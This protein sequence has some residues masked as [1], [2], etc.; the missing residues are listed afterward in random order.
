[1]RNEKL[2]GQ[3][4]DAAKSLDE[5]NDCLVSSIAMITGLDYYTVHKAL[6][7]RGRRNRCST[8]HKVAR[9]ALRDLGFSLF[10]FKVEK[11]WPQEIGLTT[12][13]LLSRHFNKPHADRIVKQMGDRF[14]AI[15]RDHAIPVL[16]GIAHDWSIDSSLRIVEIW[17]IIK[18]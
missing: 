5:S 16:N 9:D 4:N 2:I 3:I 6:K 14:I 12:K 7:I 11:D 17:K 13:N 18:R 1:M 8:P 15:T 10:E